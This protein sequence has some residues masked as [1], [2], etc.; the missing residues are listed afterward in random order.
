LNIL[1]DPIQD[2]TIYSYNINIENN[3]T[4]NGVDIYNYILPTWVMYVEDTN[5]LV[6]Y[7]S[8]FTSL[9]LSQQNILLGI[10]KSQLL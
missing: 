3:E 7:S 9:T 4:I 8:N 1:P 6:T 5:P 2:N 10:F